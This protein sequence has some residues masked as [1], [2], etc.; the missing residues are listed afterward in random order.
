[1]SRRL[2][3][4]ECSIQGRNWRQTPPGHERPDGVDRRN[5]MLCLLGGAA[6]IFTN[7][8][9]AAQTADWPD[10]PIKIIEYFPAGVARDNRTRV[11]AEKLSG[12]LGQQVYVENRPGAAGRIGLAAAAKSPPDGYTFAM[13]GP[14]DAIARHLFELPYDIERDFSPVSMIETLPV[15]AVARASLPVGNVIELAHLAKAHP[16]ELKFG[17]PGV[18]SFH[19]MNGVLFA[20]L[21]GTT[22]QHI[23]YGQGNPGADLL[24]GHIDLIFDALPPW[25]ENVK[26]GRL[27]ALAIT[28]ETRAP[29]LPD[30]PS[31]GESGLPAYDTYAFYG[32]V[33]P[34]GT[35]E[36]V[37]AKLQ[38]AIRQMVDE[39]KLNR[40]WIS[41]GGNPTAGSPDQFATTIR[42]ESERWGN[43]IR[44]NNIK[45]Q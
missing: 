22:L 32:L 41:E 44:S 12:I 28:G 15:V 7:S 10:R 1:M 36:S 14:G 21:T 35:P 5:F 13:I 29:A 38:Q 4:P 9:A 30:T 43:A 11:I 31:F 25:L 16:G 2:S 24:G 6:T 3:D 19:H 39:P 27:R 45:I 23:P 8:R 20:N 33:A 26:A 40:Q 37:I 17:S 34:K 42:T 18:G